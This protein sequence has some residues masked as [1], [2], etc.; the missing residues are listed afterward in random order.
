MASNDAA[1]APGVLGLP[2]VSGGAKRPHGRDETPI[3][4]SM[5]K[6][7]LADS[8]KKHLADTKELID[9]SSANN[10]E[11]MAAFGGQIEAKF[12]EQAQA[13]NEVS[14]RVDKVETRQDGF[15]SELEEVRA[16]Q[17]RIEA[18]LHLANKTAL[19]RADLDHDLFDRPPDLSVIK[20]TSLKFA[21]KMA[22]E[23]SITPWLTSCGVSRDIWNITFQ[24]SGKRFYIKFLLNP[25]SAGKLVLEILRNNLKDE[26]GKWREFEVK[27]VTKGTCKLIIGA[28]ESPKAG[29]QRRLAACLKKS[30][31]KLYPQIEDVHFR[32]RAKGVGA[33]VFSAKIPLASLQPESDAPEKK[34]IGWNPAALAEFGIDR[35]SVNEQTFKFFDGDAEPIQWLF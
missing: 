11:T 22:V 25:L 12:A 10:A 4:P 16:A 34:S 19:T 32:P 18:S 29:V 3:T 31:A 35:D 30:L 9:K 5:F 6:D 15:Q 7:I 20:I 17:G 14:S 24:P 23:D 27:L 8:Q 1:N 33:A 26:D 13:I 2:P 28:D 21:S